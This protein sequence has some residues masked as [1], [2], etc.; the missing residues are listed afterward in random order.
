KVACSKVGKPYVYDNT[1]FPWAAEVERGWPAIRAELDRVLTRKDALPGFHEISS[2]VAT[3]SQDRDWK[4]FL[5]C[6][7]GFTSENNNRQCPETWRIV[8]RIPGLITA[9]F[10]ILEP[11]KHLPPH[12]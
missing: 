10:S 5:L 9:M 7:Y 1:V 12:R 6:G 3:I 8:Q 2:D 11:G 4:T